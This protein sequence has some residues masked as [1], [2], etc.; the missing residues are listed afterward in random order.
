ME[1]IANILSKSGIDQY[2]AVLLAFILL[3]IPAIPFLRRRV[4]AGKGPTLRVIPGFTAL[5]RLTSQSVETGRPIHLS[6]GTQGISGQNTAQT[7]A[8]LTTLQYLAQQ[9]A[10]LGA[11]PIVSVADATALIA[12]QDMLRHT[13]EQHGEIERFN[14][15]SVTMIA[16]EPIVYASGV[17]GILAREDILANVM[18]GVFGD[19]YLLAGETSVRKDISQVVGSG[20]PQALPLM[21]ASAN[22]VLIGEE[23]FASGAYLTRIPAHIASVIVQD[24][25]RLLIVLL[26]VIGIVLRTVL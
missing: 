3:F 4:S 6:V 26:I 13:Y 16:P 22:E 17:A 10:V 12:A 23:I 5:R 8:G 19:E 20:N 7:L 11:P 2:A 24:W 15:Y 25:M 9:A 14:P 18:V 1:V 21:M